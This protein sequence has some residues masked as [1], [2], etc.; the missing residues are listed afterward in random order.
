MPVPSDP[1]DLDYQRLGVTYQK[2]TLQPANSGRHRLGPSIYV[3]THGNPEHM[4][5]IEPA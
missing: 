2:A 3:F 4:A 1:S 5:G